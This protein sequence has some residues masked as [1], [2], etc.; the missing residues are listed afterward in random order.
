[1]TRAGGAARWRDDALFEHAFHAVDVEHVRGERDGAD[2]GDADGA[3]PTHEAEQR[4]DAS[5]ARPRQWAVE[6]RRG[7]A[8]DHLAGGVGLAAERVDIAH[9]VD[10]ALDRIIARVDRLA[11]RC[12]PRMRFDQQPTRVEADELCVRPRGDPLPDVRVRDRVQRFG[13]GGELIAPDLRLAPQRDVVRRG[14]RREQ[15]R[16]LLGLKVLERAALRATVSAEAVV[17][18]APIPAPRAGL[19]EGRQDF[20]GKAVIAYAGHRALDPPFVTGRSARA[21][22]RCESAGRG[23]TRE[24]PA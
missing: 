8:T 3:V 18:E 11:A 12:L 24:T 5:H 21:R 19:L 14:R 10:A 17:I 16:L 6:Q 20:T 22:G 13:D 15:E 4:V 23:R 9:R 7:V 1:M 2:L